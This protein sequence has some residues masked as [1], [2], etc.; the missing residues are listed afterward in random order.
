MDKEGLQKKL[1]EQTN[2]LYS[3]IGEFIVEFEQVCHAISLNIKFILHNDGLKNQRIPD[4]IL[5]GLTADPLQSMLRSLIHELRDLDETEKKIIKN[6]FDRLQKL[7]KQRNDIVH[8]T[9]FIG[10]GSE[11]ESDFSVAYGMKYYKSSTSNEPKVFE[12]TYQDFNKL[13]EE[14]KKLKDVF[15]RLIGCLVAGYSI[16]KNFIFDSNGDVSVPVKSK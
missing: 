9:W 4:I 11:T 3:A 14:A 8:S 13:T 1:N 12:K 2:E 10:W 7:I 15:Q 5:A 16:K 6:I